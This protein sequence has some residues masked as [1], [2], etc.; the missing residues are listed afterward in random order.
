MKVLMFGWEF[1]PHS[2][3]GLGRVCFNLVKNLSDKNVDIIFVMPR[4][5][6]D[7]K[8]GKFISLENS[9]IKIKRVNSPLVGYMTSAQYTREVLSGK[10]PYIYGRDLFEEVENYTK[11][12]IEAIA[13]EEYD[14][15]HAHDWMTF[16]A[17]IAAKKLSGKPL[18]V[19]V[20]STEF[21]RSGEGMNQHVFEIEKSGLEYADAV[22]TVS[23]YT[24]D[25][26]IKYYGINPE[27]IHVVHNATTFEDYTVDKQIKKNHKIVLFLGRVT[28]QKGPDH[29][30]KAAK[31]VLEHDND[32][33]FVIAGSGDMESY[34][35]EKAAEL[36]IA[37]SV[38]FSGFL[39][40]EEINRIYQLADVYVLPSVSEPFGITVLEAM[41]NGVPAIVSKNSGVTEVIRHCLRV[42]FWDTHEMSNKILALLKY[43]VLHNSIKQNGLDEVS[44]MSWHK[45]A[46]R[47]IEIYKGLVGGV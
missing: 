38:L 30:L 22:I 37:D 16:K 29:F 34:I 42:D 19:H 1:P 6:T 7:L 33:K 13:D 2:I 43:D 26:I 47:C 17:G 35:I 24:K 25:K 10:K 40:E 3:G 21:D 15:I 18:I 31:K 46:E 20:H 39:K 28:F 8:F 12:A 36:G 41:K 14:I 11:M 5:N 9:R 44:K 32:V 4:G 45:P 23:N 27:K